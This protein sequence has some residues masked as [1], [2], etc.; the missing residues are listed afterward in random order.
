VGSLVYSMYP[1][2]PGLKAKS[3]NTPP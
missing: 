3:E 1:P 2:L